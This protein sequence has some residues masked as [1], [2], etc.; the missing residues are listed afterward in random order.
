MAESRASNKEFIE[1]F[2]RAEEN[3]ESSIPIDEKRIEETE[4]EE[5]ARDAKEKDDFGNEGFEDV[6]SDEGELMKIQE[7]VRESVGDCQARS[8][9]A[10]EEGFCRE[11]V[12]SFQP[13]NSHFRPSAALAFRDF[14]SQFPNDEIIE[15]KSES[16]IELDLELQKRKTKKSELGLSQEPEPEPEVEHINETPR[17]SNKISEDR[18]KESK[19]APE[20]CIDSAQKSDSNFQS[21]NPFRETKTLMAILSAGVTNDSSQKGSNRSQKL[22]NS[23]G[24]KTHSSTKADGY[25]SKNAFSTGKTKQEAKKFELTPQKIREDMKAR[26]AKP[27]VPSGYS[28]PIGKLPQNSSKGF[29]SVR[30]DRETQQA[31]AHDSER[32]HSPK[33][34][35]NTAR[36]KNQGNSKTP[37]K[38]GKKVCLP[39]D[40]ADERQM[41]EN[42]FRATTR[43]AIEDIKI[44]EEEEDNAKRKKNKRLL[45]LTSKKKMYADTLKQKLKKDLELLLF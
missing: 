41:R 36:T 11:D 13:E 32:A 25:L 4:Q 38:T 22:E 37:A 6:I 15:K 5:K 44:E 18:N 24:A 2:L 39:V 12:P 7:M 10:D 9:L 23:T 33:S 3:Q 14:K 21:T 20:S 16:R 34:G 35:N 1:D 40:V 43:L 29:N 26:L 45:D 19:A 42:N 28:H 27:W 30:A 31:R 17:V 8:S